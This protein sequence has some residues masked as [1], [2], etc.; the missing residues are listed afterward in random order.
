MK[1]TKLASG[2]HR[3]QVYYGKD[4]NGKKL[5]KSFTAPTEWE[6]LK[7]VEDFR[8]KNAIGVDDPADLTVEGAILRYIGSRS[9]ILSPSSLRSYDLI[10]RT[11]L[12]LISKHKIGKLTLIDIQS[13]VNEDAARLSRKSIR[14]AV[15][16]LY[17]AA[18]ANGVDLRRLG[19]VS[20]PM[21]KKHIKELMPVEH[22]IP[23]IVGTKLELPCLLAMWLSLRIS[24]VR[25]LKFSDISEDGK[26]ITVQRERVYCDGKDYVREINK[27]VESTR[28]N[29]L[30][31]YIL[32][33][34]NAVP[35]DSCDDFIITLGYN[36]IY[37]SFK[38]LMIK[39]GSSMTFHDLRHEF[40]TTLND[41]EIPSAYIQKLG[42]WNTD[43]IMKS[44]YTHTT[45]TKETEYQHR[46]DE[47]FSGIISKGP[48]PK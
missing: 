30:P 39:H 5:F 33:L 17:S 7:A 22:L 36:N 29:A 45:R 46:I 40:A 11:R 2:N 15:A 24:E 12:Q 21:H 41:L 19:K 48:D 27:T 31:T 47:F 35:H 4:K 20:L 3:I 23:L 38:R 37:K 32:D 10:S 28:K 9:N 14:E 26:Y 34:I 13:A 42:G 43:N 18:A 25:G 1:T 8:S 44:V 6:V 16:L